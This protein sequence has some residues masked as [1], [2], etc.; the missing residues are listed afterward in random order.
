[1][2]R[3]EALSCNSSAAEAVKA[4]WAPNEMLGIRGGFSKNKEMRG[5]RCWGGGG[6]GGIWGLDLDMFQKVGV[7]ITK[8][9]HSGF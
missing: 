6:K 5:S 3:I 7:A 4:D 1:M 9:P 2:I 8:N